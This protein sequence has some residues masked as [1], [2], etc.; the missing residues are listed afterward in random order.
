VRGRDR[1]KTRATNGAKDDMSSPS[2]LVCKGSVILF[3]EVDKS[4]ISP[5]YKKHCPTIVTNVFLFEVSYEDLL[6]AGFVALTP[7]KSRARK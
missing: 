6:D 7:S 3:P 4:L 5:Q 2:E 1:D